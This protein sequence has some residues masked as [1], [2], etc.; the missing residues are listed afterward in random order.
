[1]KTGDVVAGWTLEDR[2]GEGGTATVWRVKSG[3]RRAVLKLLR[4]ELRSDADWRA[5]LLREADA[6]R[7]VTHDNVVALLDA[8]ITEEGDPFVVMPEVVGE[9]LRA[10]LDREKKMEAREAWRVLRPIAEALAAAHDAGIVH[11]D[12][13]PDNI[14]LGD[15]VKLVDFGLARGEGVPKVTATGAPVGT[16]AYMAPEQWWNQGVGPATDQYALGVTLYEMIAGRAPWGDASFAELV[17]SHVSK[18]APRLEGDDAVA[19]F[20]ARLL[21]KEPS[22]RFASMP[23]AVAA[24]DAAFGSP[25]PRV[26][27]SP[28]SVF[29]AAYG[30]VS[31]VLFGYPRQST[32]FEW[33]RVAGWGIFITVTAFALGAIWV[34]LRTGAR[35]RVALIVAAAGTFAAASAFEAVF[36]A[37]ARTPAEEGFVLFHQGAWEA[38][39]N[40]YVGFTLASALLL[41]AEVRRARPPSNASRM[42]SIAA[43]AV[44]CV[45]VT[46]GVPSA[47]IAV[48]AFAFALI[49][50]RTPATLGAVAAASIAAITRAHALGDA[51][52][53]LEPTRAARAAAL[54]AASR[55]RAVA[56]LAAVVVTAVTLFLVRSSLRD[57]SRAPRAWLAFATIW[58][59]GDAALAVRTTIAKRAIYTRLEPEF[60]L[61]SQLDP[62]TA[63]EPSTVVPP[64]RPTLKIAR[65]RVALDTTPALVLSALESDAG[66]GVLRSDLAHR[67]AADPSTGE[68]DVLLMADE[69]TPPHVVTT[70]LAAAYDAGVRRVGVL[71]LRGAPLAKTADLPEEASYVL[72]RDFEVLDVR[73]AQGGVSLEGATFAD[74][75]T[76]VRDGDVI[77]VRT[78]R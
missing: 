78:S 49:L 50:P 17:S 41:A 36:R 20:V 63:R 30:A 70:C 26:R 42:S 77:H 46:L 37:L 10:R 25:A 52:W 2:L 57:L 75:L 14:V 53:S 5:R 18:P 29:F 21:E 8:G 73:L 55:E 45:C 71:L 4:S 13:K 24:G 54:V 61:L 68:A 15:V 48:A 76:G 67:L 40:R 23:E 33:F 7:R 22:A 58:A 64:I 31:L 38:Q 1:M 62:P 19:T 12:V 16:P 32:A 47:A 39:A 65:D 44:A 60:A 51:A 74:A 9:T 27:F 56:W 59:L 28:A 6:L 3:D 43:L 34:T 69:S 66:I 11:R 35:G 72:P